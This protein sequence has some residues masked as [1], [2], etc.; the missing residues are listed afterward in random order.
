[1]KEAP[2]TEPRRLIDYLGLA[3]DF[4]AA[5]SIDFSHYLTFGLATNRGIATHLGYSVH[6]AG[7]HENIRPTTGCN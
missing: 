5:K 4:L 6:I 7:K 2:S 1:M 3:T